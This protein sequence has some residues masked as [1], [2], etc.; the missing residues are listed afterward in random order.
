MSSVLLLSNGPGELWGW[1]RPLV[2]EL[3]ARGHRTTIAILPCPFASGSERR[4]AETLGAQEIL[5]PAGTLATVRSMLG[6]RMRADVVVQLGGDL[7]WGRLAA[8]RAGA[9]LLCYS[10]GRKKGLERCRAVFTAYPS[11]AEAMGGAVVI[12]DLVAEG[13]GPE[14]EAPA[15]GAEGS[16]VV[17]FFPGSRDAYR[18]FA[19]DFIAEV[20]DLL[21]GQFPDLSARVVLSP[22][23]PEGDEARWRERGL[24]VV[25]GG[26]REAVR[27]VDLAV[28][29]PGTNTLDLTCCAVPFM[30]MVPFAI[31]RD[32]PVSG[33]AGMVAAIPWIGPW[34]KE[35]ELRRRSRHV[36]YLAWPNRIVGRSVVD[37]YFGDITASD[38]AERIGRRLRDERWLAGTRE[39]L[40]EIGRLAP[41][42]AAKR[43]ADEIERVVRRDDQG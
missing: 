34:L 25:R 29:Q 16:P 32:L 13:L 11:M 31:L 26:G 40:R 23:A 39:A 42:G 7:L 9:P 19:E 24:F 14:E 8:W 36:T 10:Y 20:A 37:E 27:G 1:A 18:S 17:A 5:G 15:P 22:F 12:G 21:R 30:V 3:T 6:G 41:A 2:P 28:T 35:R 43:L 4:I 38:A 33:L